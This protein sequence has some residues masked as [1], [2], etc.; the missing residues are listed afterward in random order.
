M[1]LGKVKKFFG[2]AGIRLNEGIYPLHLLL[3]C[4][5]NKEQAY[6]VDRVLRR[7]GKLKALILEGWYSGQDCEDC[8]MM[9]AACTYY[10]YRNEYLPC[11]DRRNIIFCFETELPK[12]L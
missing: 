7:F 5:P 3:D 10:K 12:F 11:L 4:L 2:M 8:D 6:R 9:C 1:E